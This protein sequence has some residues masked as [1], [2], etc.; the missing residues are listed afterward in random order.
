[1]AD[2]TLSFFGKSKSRHDSPAESRR[3]IEMQG[4]LFWGLQLFLWFFVGAFAYHV[5]KQILLP[6]FSHADSLLAA[7]TRFSTA[8]TVSTALGWGYNSLFR[9]SRSRRVFFAAS[10][11][12]LVIAA[13][14]ETALFLFCVLIFNKSLLVHAND[15]VKLVTFLVHRIEFLG[16]WSLLFLGIFFWKQYQ[17]VKLQKAQAESALLASEL[18][19][20]QL[21]IHPHFLFNS[22]TAVLACRHNPDDVSQVVIGLG[23]YLQFCLTRQ[24]MRAPLAIEIEALQQYVVVEQYRF[25][26]TLHCQ[27]HCTP[28]AA[29][30]VVPTMIITPLLE[31]AFKY[32]GRTTTGQ[33]VVEVDCRIQI[34]RL[35]ITVFNTGHWIE[36]TSVKT[37]GL[38]LANLRSRLL[39]LGLT[40]AQ[41]ECGPFEADPLKKG[42]RCQLTLPLD[43]TF[44]NPD[45]QN[46]SLTSVAS[47][48][49]FREA[50]PP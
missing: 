20:L 28:D 41:L 48:P 7:T 46:P 3:L 23:E 6:R 25:G 13:V 49:L 26:E 2:S 37:G 30:A 21:Q 31:N 29:A 16:I 33:L 24:E 27:L 8:I 47:P 18:S 11:L 38:G 50:T 42:V 10:F 35:I 34:D 12:L 39:L 40:D 19:R 45:S 4:F 15:W 44:Q 32:G 36:P 43:P 9:R 1:M 5:N 14:V 17:S 22:L